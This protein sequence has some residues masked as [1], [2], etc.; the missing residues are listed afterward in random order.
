VNRISLSLLI[1]LLVP[2]HA[3][4]QQ[5]VITYHTP[6]QLS[7]SN[8]FGNLREGGRANTVAVNWGRPWEQFVA[9]D[10]GGLFMSGDWGKTWRHVDSLPVMFTQSVAYLGSDSLLV[11]AKADLR[12]VN[13]GGLWRSD[14]N[15]MTWKPVPL[16]VPDPSFT[17]RLSAYEIS[18]ASNH[19][20]VATSK[21]VF[22]SADY[23]ANWTWSDP[24]AFEGSPTFSVLVTATRVLAGGPSGVRTGTF[25][26]T[27]WRRPNT[28]P[29][30]AIWSIH[31]FG[32]SPMTSFQAY[33]INAGR[34]YLTGDQGITWVQLATPPL[35][36]AGTCGGAPFVRTGR[37]DEDTI[38][39]FYGTGCVLYRFTADIV[40]F[41]VDYEHGTWKELMIE[42]QDR[43][44]DLAVVS[45]DPMLLA[46]NAGIH[47]T[48]DAGL[49][50]K[51]AGGGLDGY[52]AMQVPELKGQFIT[53]A[54]HIDLYVGTRDNQFWA[55]DAD[56]RIANRRRQEALFV[57][58]ERKL[59][60]ETA[61][62]ITWA[63]N[64]P[65]GNHKSEWQ[66][67]LDTAW[68][69]AIGF[70]GA[71]V[72]VRGDQY[73][74]P[75]WTGLAM[76]TTA[77]QPW[78][79]YAAFSED[80]RGLPKFGRGKLDHLVFYQTYKSNLPGPPA[81]GATQLLRIDDSP[82]GGSVTYPAMSGLGGLGI[83]R[84]P[85]AMYPVYA[86]DPRNASHIIAPDITGDPM[87]QRVK[88]TTNGGA[89]W[90]EI[91]GLT[92][93]ITNHGER[94]MVADLADAEAAPLVTAISFCPDDPSLVLIGTRQGGI[95][96]SG[97]RGRTWSPIDNSDRIP[98]VTSFFWVDANTIYV[99]SYGRGLWKLQNIQVAVPS[100]FGDFCGTCGVIAMDGS[101]DP[102]FDAALLA[103]NGRIL[104]TRTEKG[105]LREVFVTQGSSVVFTGDEKYLPG[106]ITVTRSNGR[107]TG[108]PLPKGPDGTIATAV[109]FMSDHTLA[110]AA[111][112]KSE[113]SLLPPEA[114]DD[115]K[116]STDSP[117]KGMPYV[118]LM[119][120]AFN[121]VATAVPSEVFSLSGTDFVA[122]ASYDVLLDG[123][124]TGEKITADK[125]GS[126]TARLA[127]PSDAGYHRIEVR[128]AAKGDVI[129][130][131]DL[132]VIESN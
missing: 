28:S 100:A 123:V 92:D 68:S 63:R 53:S 96:M 74:Q 57:D 48:L 113:L 130:G 23:G 71:P 115:Y 56:L 7:A 120:P 60:D 88:E 41:A 38:R 81:E 116:G 127:A 20:A 40:E 32:D 5:K 75:L 98:W 36:P 33:M 83:V 19:V 43:P 78:Q 18:V 2:L 99:S 12:A 111:F 95:Y 29:L 55:A 93:A 37:L 122:G 69:D 77:G 105:V 82:A 128:D 11:S 46:A 8:E 47:K 35:Q 103:F 72:L 64:N 62:R 126:L 58:A 45:G 107:D 129:D 66:L 121:G 106:D 118:R 108:D 9:S 49:H 87:N 94:L 79:N 131:S 119:A 10:S 109:V 124:A 65:N 59:F 21:G 90:H 17:G 61:S 112:A 85:A 1:T 31:A 86:V 117:A 44:R 3:F 24:F 97:D 132:L 73:V 26:P 30:G 6:I 91:P 22:L 50:W 27:T 125:N 89:A 42:G 101:R 52:N 54:E 104:A 13:G 51:F 76:T 114:G 102:R 84:T 15:G 14:D 16:S 39:L 70:N 25:A 34:L 80:Q 110:G 4:A 67:H